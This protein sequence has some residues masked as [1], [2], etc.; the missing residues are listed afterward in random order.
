MEMGDMVLQIMYEFAYTGVSDPRPFGLHY[1][2]H[3]ALVGDVLALSA[4]GNW[5]D[6]IARAAC[7]LGTPPA[8]S[9]I[10][11]WMC[12]QSISLLSGRG[13]ALS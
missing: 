7:F 2:H 4:P 6:A 11:D 8:H 12:A 13:L 5:L 1:D 9:D 3:H 10:L